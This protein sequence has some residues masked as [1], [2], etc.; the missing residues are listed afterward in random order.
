MFI[1]FFDGIVFG[2]VLFLVVFVMVC[3]FLCEVFFVVSWVGLVYVVYKFYFFVL[4][5]VQ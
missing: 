3:G 2:V 1:M 4:F 5:Y